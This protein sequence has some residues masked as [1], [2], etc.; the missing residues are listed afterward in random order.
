MKTSKWI[1][2]LACALMVGMAASCGEKPIVSPDDEV[3]PHIT[4]PAPPVEVDPTYD[5]GEGVVRLVSYNVGAFNKYTNSIDMI[6][7]MIKELD[8]DI[9]GLNEVDSCTTRTGRVDQA[10]KLSERLGGWTPVL[11]TMHPYKEGGYGNAIV[12]SPDYKLTGKKKIQLPKVNSS[13]EIRS[14]AVAINDK[15]VYMATHLEVNSEAARIQGAQTITEWAKD[16]YGNSDMP[17]FLCGDMN[18]EPADAP[19]KELQK[20]WTLISVTDNTYPSNPGK[21]CIDFIFA[22]KNKAQYEVVKSEVPLKFENGDVTKA[23]DH[24]PIYVDVKLK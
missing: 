1:F 3:P 9:V 4:P 12:M 21:K 18:C 13:H 14:C 20:N 15:F 16:K 24:L 11:A 23:S 6:A 10:R 17:V 22:L 5:K 2:M 7:K 19:I 8:A